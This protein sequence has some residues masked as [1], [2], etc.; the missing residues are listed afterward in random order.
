MCCLPDQWCVPDRITLPLSRIWWAQRIY[1]LACPHWMAGFPRYCERVNLTALL[2]R[3]TYNKARVHENI[4]HEEKKRR[5]KQASDPASEIYIISV[6]G[7]LLNKVP[8]C[9]FP[10]RQP[11]GLQP[12]NGNSFTFDLVWRQNG[13]GSV[14]NRNTK[15][16]RNR[17]PLSKR[18][19]E[20]KLK[21]LYNIRLRYLM[22]LL[23][24]RR[25]RAPLFSSTRTPPILLQWL[26]DW[27]T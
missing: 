23:L 14:T 27:T 9:R 17:Y 26:W 4:W 8:L 20:K 16:L 13:G 18:L 12:Y 25:A 21:R 19:L 3:A 7:T 1:P 2:S 24:L 11:V 15:N 10:I 22:L 6:R 5:R